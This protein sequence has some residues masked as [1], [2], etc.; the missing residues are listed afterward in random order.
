MLTIMPSTPPMHFAPTAAVDSPL[1]NPRKPPEPPALKIIPPTPAEELERELAPTNQTRDG[2]TP[3][4]R[5]S[6]AQKARRY[7]DS[8]IQPLLSRTNGSIRRS[9]QQPVHRAPSVGEQQDNKLHPFWRPRGFWDDFSDSDED[10]IFFEGRRSKN[11]GDSDREVEPGH[12]VTASTRPA[13]GFLIG[14]TLG[15]SRAGTNVRRHH[16]SLPAALLARH[17]HPREKGVIMRHSASS[18][19]SSGTWDS[20]GARA[21]KSREPG[22]YNIPG[23]GLQFQY[24]GLRGV[25]EKFREHQF[26]QEEKRREVKRNELR[27]KI[28]TRFVVDAGRV[29]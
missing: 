9:Q 23:L 13:G 27:R 16:V 6:L 7:S 11:T 1:K 5:A 15:V 29:M 12:A 22:L 2:S 8:L 25:R 18:L 4:R 19:R 21:M 28:G 26:K 3:S 14:N 20:R 24:I 10:S 17:R